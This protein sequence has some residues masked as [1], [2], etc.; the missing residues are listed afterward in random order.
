MLHSKWQFA[1]VQAIAIG[2]LLSHPQASSA[3]LLPVADDT[4]GSERSI[5]VPLDAEIPGD[6]INGGA[7]RSNN[8]F[9]SFRDFH[10]DENRGVYFTDPGVE[11]ILTRVTGG[12]TSQ[13]LGV[14][15]VLGDA[16]LFLINPNGI[17]FGKDSRL[18][19]GGD[20]TATTADAVQ[21]GAQGIFDAGNPDVPATLTIQPS[22]FLFNQMNPA[23]IVSRSVIPSSD[24]F[25]T[26]KTGSLRVNEGQGL[27]LLGGDISIEGGGF[28]AAGRDRTPNKIAAPGGRI[29]IGGLSE[30]GAVLLNADGSLS[31][32]AGVLRADVS[33]SKDVAI[34]ASDNTENSGSIAINAGNLDIE[35]S[36]LTTG[37]TAIRP[38]DSDIELN[39]DSIR[40]ERTRI[41]TSLSLSAATDGGGSGDI[42]ITTGSLLLST[43]SELFSGN[44]DI[45]V[46]GDITIQASGDVVLDKSEISST[47]FNLFPFQ[48]G[49]ADYGG[50]I[51]IIADSLLLTNDSSITSD[52]LRLGGGGG[53]GNITIQVRDRFSMEGIEEASPF[54]R[55]PSS[56]YISTGKSPLLIELS[57]GESDTEGSGNIQISAD[58]VRLADGGYIDASSGSFGPGGTINVTANT[59]EA[60]SGGYIETNTL[61][62]GT[63]GD[64]NLDVAERVILSGGPEDP[65]KPPSGLYASAESLGTFADYINE[66]AEPSIE[67]TSGSV[68][69]TTDRLQVLNG[70]RIEVDSRGVATG[71]IN[72][73]AKIVELSNGGSLSA[74][75]LSADGGNITVQ[76]AKLLKLRNGSLI[77]ATAGTE[78]AGGNGGNISIASELIVAAPDENSDIRANAFSGSGGSVRINSSGLFGIA[79]QSQDNLL[80]S[81]ITASSELGTPG[82]VNIDIPE[83]D[84]DSG[85]TELP[86][87]FADASNQITQTCT[88]NRDGRE[89]EFVITGRGGLPSSPTDTLLGGTSLVDWAMLSEPTA[90]P[91]ETVFSSALPSSTTALSAEGGLVEAQGWTNESGV[92]ALVTAASTSAAQPTAMVCSAP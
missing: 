22:A 42:R 12:S 73:T 51:S 6:R 48:T 9:H 58:S 70:A 67:G 18:E 68:R 43:R 81:D 25:T 55:F 85:L 77:S 76:G 49:G 10:I 69:V 61:S 28:R 84:P 65:D 13:I 44:R 92:V 33:I 37:T 54:N 31:F 87:A 27:T 14:L 3:Q 88:G 20:F 57:P 46:S 11:N 35:N 29:E 17:T 26:R 5:V 60:L 16:N 40:A 63:A 80:T 24:F 7:L 41:I 38:T 50:D 8:L 91:S 53:V 2:A 75:T 59:F 47:V 66:L 79:A 72:I 86:V 19:V 74:E 39:A 21:F 62:S 36:V 32:P 4:L 15:G 78:G 64:I 82:T 56:G 90:L 71:D 30:A 23:P 89:S 45:G 83:T 1:S 52:N 34:D